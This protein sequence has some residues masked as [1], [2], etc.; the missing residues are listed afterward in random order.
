MFTSEAETRY[1]ARRQPKGGLFPLRYDLALHQY[2]ERQKEQNEDTMAIKGPSSIG[3]ALSNV[4]S[5]GS[6]LFN[7]I[8][9]QT[10]GEQR[11]SH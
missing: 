10:S 5:V 4:M 9:A 3:A 2:L 7:R 6:S 11:G 1:T 8:N